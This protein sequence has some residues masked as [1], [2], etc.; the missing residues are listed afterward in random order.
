VDAL[1]GNSIGAEPYYCLAQPGALY[2]VYLPWGGV[3]TIDLRGATGEFSVQWFNP[4]TG[5]A[6]VDGP[7]KVVSGGARARLGQPPTE[8]QEDWVILLRRQSAT[9]LSTD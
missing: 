2:L 4:R 1:M 9:G 7:V 5:G 8:K 6:L 3:S